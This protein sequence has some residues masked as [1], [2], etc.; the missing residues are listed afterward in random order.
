MHAACRHHRRRG[1][2][3]EVLI[4]DGCWIQLAQR[5]LDALGGTQAFR[6][7]Q[8]FDVG[9]AHTV[10]DADAAALRE[11]HIFTRKPP[12]RH[13]GVQRAG[14]TMGFADRASSHTTST[15]IGSRFAA[16]YRG[17][18]VNDRSQISKNAGSRRSDALP[19]R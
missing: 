8:A 16:S 15:S 7:I 6:M 11:K 1:G 10:D 18:V 5:R 3:D 14:I 9:P 4:D 13:H 17:F 19:A 12:R 2:F